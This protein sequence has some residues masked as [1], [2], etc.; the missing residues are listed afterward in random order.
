MSSTFQPSSIAVGHVIIPGGTLTITGEL[1]ELFDAEYSARDRKL[2]AESEALL[3]PGASLDSFANN[4]AYKHDLHPG[5]SYF[6]HQVKREDASLTLEF[7]YRVP[8]NS[9]PLRHGLR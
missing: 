6:L 4:F 2:D 9:Q 7:S 1:L 8:S 5:P 3:G